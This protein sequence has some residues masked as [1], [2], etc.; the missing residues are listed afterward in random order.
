M[1]KTALAQ[2]RETQALA[3]FAADGVV[4]GN[5]QVLSG[6]RWSSI[7]KRPVL[8]ARWGLA[9]VTVQPAKPGEGKAA[10]GGE[11]RDTGGP[12]ATPSGN[13]FSGPIGAAAAPP[14][15]PT[16]PPAVA[17][18]AAARKTGKKRLGENAAL[19]AKNS[20]DYAIP[21]PIAFWHQNVGE[22]L[23]DALQ[24]R[25]SR[26]DFGTLL[27]NVER[28]PVAAAGAAPAAEAP[29]AAPG[30][31]PAAAPGAPAPAAAAVAADENASAATP[32]SVPGVMLLDGTGIVEL[33]AAAI[34]ENLDF[35]MIAM[36]S[37]KPIRSGPTQS[38][39]A[40]HIIDLCKGG[41]D[42]KSKDVNHV[43]VIAAQQA[44]Q[45][46]VGK[47]KEENPL[48]SLIKSTVAHIDR[49]CQLV[50]MPSLNHESALQA[51]RRAERDEGD[52]PSAGALGTALLPVEEGIDR[53]GV[54]R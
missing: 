54:R 23:L 26:G 33:R 41:E 22:P 28:K 1:A 14:P 16:P 45:Q 24:T 20:A 44:A 46:P 15:G 40:I 48:P 21:D 29:Q 53:P 42:W 31:P 13:I 7:L 39:L 9:T 30:G 47:E 4:G 8:V 35:L 34:R 32:S 52:Q 25:S 19:E 43:R 37:S 50:E 38:V 27:K 11:P 17:G 49:E 6:L 51:R 12:P 36:I 2:G 3:Y 5:E 18:G 10:R